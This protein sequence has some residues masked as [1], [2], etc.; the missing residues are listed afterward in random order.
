MVSATG[1]GRRYAA[2]ALVRDVLASEG[3]L[4]VALLILDWKNSEEQQESRWP[5][6]V[7][8]PQRVRVAVRGLPAP[9]DAWRGSYGQLLGAAAGE[10]AVDVAVSIQA[11]NASLELLRSAVAA[12]CYVAMGHDYNLPYGP[13]GM[14]AEEEVTLRSRQLLEHAG[15]VML[16]TSRHLTDYVHRFSE[17]KVRSRLCYCADYGYF[18]PWKKTTLRVPPRPVP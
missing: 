7:E 9:V 10:L 1:N 4:L 8:G 15:T 14:A 13:W 6:P 2:Q 17:G 5:V 3:L 16:C 12:R 18:D 11:R